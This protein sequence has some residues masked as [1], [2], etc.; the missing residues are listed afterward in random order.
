MRHPIDFKSPRKPLL[1]VFVASYNGFI[2]S[3][4]IPLLR[5]FRPSLRGC[6]YVEIRQQSPKVSE[7]RER[8]EHAP[9]YLQPSISLKDIP[10]PVSINFRNLVAFS[11]PIYNGLGASAG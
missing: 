8:F 5:C 4:R 1:A 11:F 7:K 10:L 2:L 3:S 9:A 6:A